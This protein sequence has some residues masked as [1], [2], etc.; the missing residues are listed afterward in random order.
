MGRMGNVLVADRR[1]FVV[2]L[3]EAELAGAAA[4]WQEGGSIEPADEESK[5]LGVVV[6]QFHLVMTG[7]EVVLEEVRLA[8]EQLLV[9]VP[10]FLLGPDHDGDEAFSEPPRVETETSALG[11]SRFLVAKVLTGSRPTRTESR[12]SALDSSV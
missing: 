9:D 11:R 3:R 7:G 1:G 8:D 4:H 6:G 10:A 2:R 12:D 5:K